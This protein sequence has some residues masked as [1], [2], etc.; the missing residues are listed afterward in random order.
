M[1]GD[2][3]LKHTRTKS[4]ATY[5]IKFLLVIFSLILVAPV[6]ADYKQAD[7]DECYFNSV[8]KHFNT[9]FPVCKRAAEQGDVYAQIFLGDML[10]SDGLDTPKDDKQAVYWFTKAAEQGVAQAQR[11]LGVMFRNGEG[12]PKDDKQAVYW[13]TKAAEQGDAGAQSLLV[14]MFRN[15]EGTPKD[16]KQ[17]VYWF[18][19]AAE[20]GVAQV[21]GLLAVMFRNG[22]G[23]PK[24]NVMAYVWWNIS[25]AQGN[26]MAKKSREIIEE[27]MTPKQI[28]EAQKLSKEYY[29]KYVK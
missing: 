5:L 18:T 8:A 2:V 16:D 17:A 26:E 14:V 1:K 20:Q 15:G 24:D 29:A 23:T 19:K 12:T 21:Q 3:T 25:A 4:P 11:L 22:E 28:A 9:A 7:I 10:R 13:F 6:L 27:E